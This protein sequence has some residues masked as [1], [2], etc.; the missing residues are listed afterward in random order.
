[1]ENNVTWLR[2][3]QGWVIRPTYQPT[4]CVSS[5]LPCFGSEG[6][7]P[8]GSRQ[9]DLRQESPKSGVGTEVLEQKGEG[10]PNMEGK[11]AEES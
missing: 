3:E 4:E 2:D 9:A 1:M 8:H 7:A 11:D 6:T 5:K 10:H